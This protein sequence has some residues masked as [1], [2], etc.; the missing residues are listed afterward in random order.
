MKNTPALSVCVPFYPWYREHD[1]TSEVFDVLIKGLNKC[2]R[3]ESMELCILDAGVVDVWGRGRIHYSRKF[4]VD[5][6]RSFKGH[7]NYKFDEGSIHY[8]DKGIPRFWVAKAVDNA[9][10]NSSSDRILIFGIDCYASSDLMD[11]YDKNVSKG[12]A[13]V[14]LA[15]NIPA[16]TKFEKGGVHSGW[17]TAKGIV[18]IL[19]KDYFRVGGYNP[20]YIK[21]K[22]DSDFYVRIAQKFKLVMNKENGFFHV[23]HPG[24]NAG[25]IWRVDA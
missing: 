18:G 8:D 14:I 15:Y 22:C 10:R 6:A 23:N 1:R 2:D 20:Q 13:W 5:L 3:V 17:H 4:Q 12:I 25:R 21:D 11:R 19:K 24:S 7:V 9:V 16:F